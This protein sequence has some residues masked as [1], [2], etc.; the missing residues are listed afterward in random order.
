MVKAMTVQWE[1]PGGMDLGLQ[2]AW[3][4]AFA[5]STLRSATEVPPQGMRPPQ[6]TCRVGL[7]VCS[8]YISNYLP[9]AQLPANM[10]MYI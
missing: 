2:R 6:S 5:V 4:L 10:L 3:L 9:A 1:A 7:G 8:L